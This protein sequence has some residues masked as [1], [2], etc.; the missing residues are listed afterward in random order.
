MRELASAAAT[1]ARCR[2]ACRGSSINVDIEDKTCPCCQ[3]EL[4]Q[5]STQALSVF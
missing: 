5:P 3:G 1:V 4:H 2:R